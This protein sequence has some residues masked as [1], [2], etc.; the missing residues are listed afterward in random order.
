MFSFLVGAAGGIVDGRGL[1]AALAL[2]A[3]GVWIG[4]RFIAS[5]EAHAG[6]VYKE[7]I[8]AAA[9]ADTRV[10]RC[11]SGKPMRVLDNP[12][13]EEW[14]TRPQDLKPFPMQAMLSGQAGV[15]GG[16]AGQL[17][18]LDP[19]KSCLPAGQGA[20]AI[21][22]VLTAAEI[23]ERFMTEAA[24]VMARLGDLAHVRAA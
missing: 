10:T 21:G 3:E 15:L 2:G 12:Y 19:A 16:I 23:V 20:G 14:E 24:E 4:T 9:D 6:Q 7:R 8:L 17:D 18:D 22:E 5:A 13:V 11:Y 1:A